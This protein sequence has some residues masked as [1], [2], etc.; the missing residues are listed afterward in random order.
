MMKALN[1]RREQKAEDIQVLSA[2]DTQPDPAY[3]SAENFQGFGVRKLAFTLAAVSKGIKARTL[4]IG[5][6]N[7]S[8][9][10][11]MLKTL[12]PGQKQ[13]LITHGVEV[14]GELSTVQ[15]RMLRAATQILTVSHFTRNI[16]I[17]K[18]GVPAAKVSIFRNTLDPSFVAGTDPGA[19]TQ[20]RSHYQIPEGAGIL[21][22]IARLQ[23]YEKAKGYDKVIEVVARLKAENKIVYYILGGK[24]SGDEY[25]RIQQLAK[26]KQV[27]QQ[28][29]LPGYLSDED[30]RTHYCLADVFI[31][32]STK[33][34]FGIVFIE[35]M[36]NG[37]PVIAGNRDGSRDTVL[38]PELGSLVDPENQEEILE[39]TR[40]WLQKGK[41]S[42]RAHAHLISEEFGFSKFCARVNAL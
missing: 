28:V 2:Y 17:E 41:A 32:P 6:I 16:L 15:K 8:I 9:V 18:H 38:S 20:L 27:E 5:H 30:L 3:F 33:E 39:A 21:L 13:I 14:W 10:G 40:F 1:L 36:A 24:Y 23:H 4:L 31:M 11:L 25:A 37:T 26:E 7:L 22:T 42:A 29:I 12:R 19:V 35:A 34:G